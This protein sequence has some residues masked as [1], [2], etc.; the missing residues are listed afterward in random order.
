MAALSEVQWCQPENKSWVRF[1]DSADDFCAIYDIMGY[2]HGRHMFDAQGKVCVNKEKGCVEVILHA[3]GKTPVRYTLDGSDPTSDS[4]LYTKPLE[5]R[6]SCTLKAK[7][8]I[9]GSRVFTRAFESHLAM[10]RPVT[11]ITEPHP[12]YTFCCPDMLTDGI[13]SEGPYNSGAYAGWYNKPMEVVI[14]MNGESYNEVTLST[15]ILKGDWIFGPKKIAVLTSADGKV[16]TEIASQVIEDNGLMTEGN[17]CQDF[18]LK[19]ADTS[20]KHLKVIADTFTELPEWH[21]GAG[22]PGFLFVDEIVVK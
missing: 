6:K 8:D 17:G 2:N 20:E 11:M 16:Y 14:E 21:P 12:N 13:A 3:Q 18:T 15:Y 5:I 1:F 9:E 4:P 10:G 7:S 22:H 19:F